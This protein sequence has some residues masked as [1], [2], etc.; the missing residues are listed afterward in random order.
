MLLITPNC[1]GAATDGQHAGTV[2]GFGI[3]VPWPVTTFHRSFTPETL[4]E[5]SLWMVLLNLAVD[6]LP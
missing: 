6:R 1:Q 3:R 5:M 2:C 4:S